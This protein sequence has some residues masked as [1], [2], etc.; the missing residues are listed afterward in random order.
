MWKRSMAAIATVILMTVL[1]VPLVTPSQ[2]APMVE[3]SMDIIPERV[4]LFPTYAQIGRLEFQGN[5]YCNKTRPDEIRVNI[6]ASVDVD[7]DFS[8]Q[9]NI[10][11]FRGVGQRMHTFDI[12]LSV[13]PRTAGPPVV[14]MS[15]RAFTDLAGR[16][17]ECTASSTLYIVQDAHEFIDSFPDKIIVPPDRGVDG[18]VYIENILDEELEVHLSVGGDWDPLIPDLDFQQYIVLNPY[19]Q[20]PAR[21]HGRLS[22]SV[23]PGD[24]LVEMVLWTPGQGSER[25][26][27]TSVNTTLQVSDPMEEGLGDTIIRSLVPILI[28]SGVV[29]GLVTYWLHRRKETKL[30]RNHNY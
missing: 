20:R 1:A 2:G 8:V 21:F 18:T 6:E 12:Y 19:E 25:T 3:L 10:L 11:V 30:A 23:E 5:V 22:S 28:L 26:V 27:I 9:P 16:T 7:W 24:Y 17:V 15:Y 13:P 29:L 14:Q 4:Q